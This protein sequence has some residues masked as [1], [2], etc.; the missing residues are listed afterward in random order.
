M[1]LASYILSSMRDRTLMLSHL[2]VLGGA[3]KSHNPSTNP[4]PPKS[5]LVYDMAQA[6][7]TR[8]EIA[9]AMDVSLSDLGRIEGEAKC[10]IKVT[11]EWLSKVRETPIHMPCR[12][13]ITMHKCK[14]CK[15]YIKDEDLEL[16]KT[17]RY[18][19]LEA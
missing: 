15:S 6:G 19:V 3:D 2:L 14:K 8:V 12:S 11:K 7:K 10:H 13:K 18:V 4:A 5:H 16:L 9:L 1:T 17:Q